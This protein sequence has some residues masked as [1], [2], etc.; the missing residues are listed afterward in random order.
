MAL[1]ESL[2]SAGQKQE[3]VPIRRS[4]TSRHRPSGAAYGR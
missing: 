1:P 2:G 4:D 3:C